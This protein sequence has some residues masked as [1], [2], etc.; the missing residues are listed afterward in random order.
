MELAACRCAVCAQPHE[1]EECP[2]RVAPSDIH[3]FPEMSG[4]YTSSIFGILAGEDF[5]QVVAYTQAPDRV[6][7]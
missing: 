3:V 7:A 6:D 2:Q 5:G 1:H 4:L